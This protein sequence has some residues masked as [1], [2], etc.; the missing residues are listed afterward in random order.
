MKLTPHSQYDETPQVLDSRLYYDTKE[1][2]YLYHEKGQ[3]VG[4]YNTF[5]DAA[6]QLS[7]RGNS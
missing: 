4:A 7:Q 5:A 3:L 6:K 2:V 1:K